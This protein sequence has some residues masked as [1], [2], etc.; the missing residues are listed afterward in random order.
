MHIKLLFP[1]EQY[2]LDIV[3]PGKLDSF[4]K[5]V[6]CYGDAHH[7]YYRGEHHFDTRGTSNLAELYH[8]LKTRVMIQPLKKEVTFQHF[9]VGV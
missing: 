6:K 8:L 4:N 7:V 1:V 2:F 3:C 5:F 9:R